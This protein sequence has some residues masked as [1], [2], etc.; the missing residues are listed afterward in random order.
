LKVLPLNSIRF[1]FCLAVIIALYSC[2]SS[3]GIASF[4]K[5]KYTKGY[6]ADVPAERPG[7]VGKEGSNKAEVKIKVDN[8]T[9]LPEKIKPEHEEFTKSSVLVKEAIKHNT[10]VERSEILKRFGVAVN[11]TEKINDD[12]PYNETTTRPLSAA[13][14][15]FYV[16]ILLLLLTILFYAVPGGPAGIFFLLALICLIVAFCLPKSNNVSSGGNNNN[17]G[18]Y[19]RQSQPKKTNNN[20]NGLFWAGIILLIFSI[21][22]GLVSVLVL[23]SALTGG[24][25]SSGLVTAAVVV[26]LLSIVGFF[27]GLILA[28]VGA[29]QKTS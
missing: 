8:R 15:L 16:S 21:V 20:S 29:A 18:D 2:S 14:I 10:K 27:T 7:V 11:K 17:T 6:F 3:D 4:G 24:G 26:L 9:V 28:I 1:F 5:R 25:L 22:F 13:R 23:A 19:V 12:K